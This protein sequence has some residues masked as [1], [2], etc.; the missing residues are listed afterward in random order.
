MAR[1]N[2]TRPGLRPRNLAGVVAFVGALSSALGAGCSEDPT[3]ATRAD[4]SAATEGGACQRLDDLTRRA[5]GNLPGI[6]AWQSRVE[7]SNSFGNLNFILN[8]AGED[9]AGAERIKGR[10]RLHFTE[11]DFLDPSRPIYRAADGD[12]S[13]D[14]SLDELKQLLLTSLYE[15]TL[16]ED[17]AALSPARYLEVVVALGDAFDDCSANAAAPEGASATAP[18]GT[19]ALTAGEAGPNGGLKLGRPR[20]EKVGNIMSG[21]FGTWKNGV[22]AAAGCVSSLPACLATKATL[23]T[24]GL[25]MFSAGSCT[26]AVGAQLTFFAQL[27]PAAAEQAC[28]YGVAVPFLEPQRGCSCAREL[29]AGARM[30]VE[31]DRVVCYNCPA[32]TAFEAAHG[33]IGDRCVCGAYQGETTLP[34]AVLGA[35][36]TGDYRAICQGTACINTFT[37]ASGF[38]GRQYGTWDSTAGPLQLPG[39]WGALPV[40]SRR[41]EFTS[42]GSDGPSGFAEALGGVC[43]RANP[44][45]PSIG[46]EYAGIDPRRR[47]QSLPFG[48][49]P[50]DFDDRSS[51]P[52]SA[53][54]VRDLRGR[55]VE[56]GGPFWC[57]DQVAAATHICT[58]ADQDAARQAVQTRNPPTAPPPPGG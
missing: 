31:F 15:D 33:D 4:E 39:V 21:L 56:C 37:T 47:P 32:S 11:A 48:S 49:G 30:H 52:G 57:A 16:L 50:A 22:V 9:A 42:C 5:P 45:G 55:T 54:G 44:A 12:P 43:D 26:A 6:A 35:P 36:E 51:R 25:C 13:N 27:F 3:S 41:A 29:L 19:V 34:A 20:L 58:P 38:D 17:G 7:F 28:E 10:L 8:Y 40:N 18:G 24:T 2:P 14:P 53:G 1:Y 23:M 46:G